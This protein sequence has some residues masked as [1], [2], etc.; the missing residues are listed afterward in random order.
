MQV[1]L[2][3]CTHGSIT[4]QRPTNPEYVVLL[5]EVNLTC[6]Y[7]GTTKYLKNGVPDNDAINLDEE[8]DVGDEEEEHE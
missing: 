8:H 3:S 6:M 5:S 4:S 7:P 1:M 2:Q